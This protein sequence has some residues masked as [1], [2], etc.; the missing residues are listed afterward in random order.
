MASVTA[1]ATNERPWSVRGI[2]YAAV[3][4]LGAEDGAMEGELANGARWWRE[5]GKENLGEGKVLKP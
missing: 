3:R 1:S 4:E 2:P 5:E